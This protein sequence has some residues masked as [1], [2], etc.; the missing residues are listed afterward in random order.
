MINHLKAIF[1]RHGIP[2]TI[3]S[4]NGREYSS[5]EFS[6]F[7]HEWGFTQI[8]SSPKYPQSN[9]DAEHMVQTMKN[10]LT[11]AKHPYE[12]M[13]AYRA[14]P[15][16]NGYSPAELS[17]GR[18]L[19]TT[20]PVIPSKLAPKWPELDKLREKEDQIKAK[21]TNGYNKRHTARELSP[22]ATGDR[23]YIPDRKENAV[24]R[25]NRCHLTPNPK[26]TIS[27]QNLSLAPAVKSKELVLKT[28][29]KSCVSSSP[30]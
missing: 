14:T 7:V 18:R 27:Q 3:V 12:A 2:E 13:L 8:T 26:G 23:V 24:V 22:L 6:K 16:E 5:A 30:K 1:A 21:Q 15:L 19:R 4:D 20:L 9:G 28:V 10:F 11:K 17:M 25:R 29:T